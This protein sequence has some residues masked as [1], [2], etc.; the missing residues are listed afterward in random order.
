MCLMLGNA[1]VH[2]PPKT[3]SLLVLSSSPQFAA[4]Q[5]NALQVQLK[6]EVKEQVMLSVVRSINY[7]PCVRVTEK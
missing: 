5:C 3:A 1:S 2:L 6:S 4:E 7:V